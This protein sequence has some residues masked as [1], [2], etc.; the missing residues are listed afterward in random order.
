MDPDLG[1]WNEVLKSLGVFGSVALGA[2]NR[3]RS[4]SGSIVNNSPEFSRALNLLESFK[5]KLSDKEFFIIRSCEWDEHGEPL[6]IKKDLSSTLELCISDDTKIPADILS[7]TKM[8][9][10]RLLSHSDHSIRSLVLKIFPFVV[11]IYDLPSIKKYLNVVLVRSLLEND[12]HLDEREESLKVIRWSFSVKIP[13]SPEISSENSTASIKNPLLSSLLVRTLIS[14]AEHPEDK[15]RNVVLESLCE[16]LLIDPSIIVNNNGLKVL[17]NGALDG[18]L[19]VTIAVVSILLHFI[20][21]PESRKFIHFNLDLE[22]LVSVITFEDEPTDITKERSKI[23]TYMLAQLLKSWSGLLYIVSG[24]YSIIKSLL[25]SLSKIHSHRISILALLFELFGLANEF[26][27]YK[28]SSGSHPFK[29][30]NKFNNFLGLPS[31]DFSLPLPLNSQFRPVEFFRS[32]LLNIFIH[33]GLFDSLSSII[34]SEKNP[35]TIEAVIIFSKWISK[36]PFVHIPKSSSQLIFLNSKFPILYNV[37]SNFD[38]KYYMHILS[39]LESP[40]NPLIKNVKSYLHSNDHQAPWLQDNHISKIN[41]KHSPKKLE[42]SSTTPFMFDNSISTPK[43]PHKLSFSEILSSQDNSL[44]QKTLQNTSNSSYK[45]SLDLSPISQGETNSSIHPEDSFQSIFDNTPNIPSKTVKRSIPTELNV[46]HSPKIKS[47]VSNLQNKDL[48]SILPS[49]NDASLYGRFS[50]DSRPSL[51]SINSS[52]SSKIDRTNARDVLVKNQMSIATGGLMNKNINKDDKSQVRSAFPYLKTSSSAVF[53]QRQINSPSSASFVHN[54]AFLNPAPLPFIRKNQ[55]KLKKDKLSKLLERSLVLSKES[56]MDWDWDIIAQILFDDALKDQ[57]LLDELIKSSLFLHR[58]ARFYMPSGFDFCNLGDASIG[59]ICCEV[60]LQLV[61]VLMSSGDG[62]LFIE[63]CNL[64][65]DIVSHLQKLLIEHPQSPFPRIS[66]ATPGQNQSSCFTN[67]FMKSNPTVKIY[68]GMLNRVAA[69]N[70]GVKYLSSFD[71]LDKEIESWKEEEGINYIFYTELQI[72][73]DLAHG[74]DFSP[75][76]PFIDSHSSYMTKEIPMHLFGQL[77]FCDEGL[78]VL[79]KNEIISLLVETLENIEWHSSEPIDCLGLKATIFALGS[80]G[81]S[82]N[83]FKAL[84][85]HNIVQKIINLSKISKVASIKGSCLF[86]LGMLSRNV[87]NAKI[88]DNFGWENCF[89]LNNQYQYAIPKF[90][91]EFFKVKDWS[92]PEILDPVLSHTNFLSRSYLLDSKTKITKSLKN[93]TGVQDGKRSS[94]KELDSLQME[95]LE[96]ICSL[97]SHLLIAANSKKLMKLRASH[98]HYFR[99]RKLFELSMHIM[100]S[101]KLRFSTRRFIFGLFDVRPLEFFS[102][103]MIPQSSEDDF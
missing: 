72:S 1:N 101:F 45:K 87:K 80:I 92:K 103:T 26:D 90:L 55:F 43:S 39:V 97:T 85:E 57:Q 86:V 51:S 22:V 60:G 25:N 34:Q 65:S 70:N 83:G 67:F 48:S 36:N 98:P 50:I 49:R 7:L 4:T 61:K 5:R 76:S 2:G 12:T 62:M 54:R 73:K 46:L 64:V 59:P 100:S 35:E 74:P 79:H 37:E 69:T 17:I 91:D 82:E 20:D 23:A 84:T 81:V 15:L 56:H 31:S 30:S 13:I 99:I 27:S 102:S 77:G 19:H 3:T 63:E 94:E 52:S 96:T 11:S 28:N 16:I 95:I 44:S 93:G 89:S 9:I 75:N 88:L 47:I 24:D 14:I 42:K 58:L 71:L 53:N 38:S 32:L 41:Y 66:P 40:N 29:D 68:F 18:P 6:E 78:K 10:P 21:L 8:Y 33:F